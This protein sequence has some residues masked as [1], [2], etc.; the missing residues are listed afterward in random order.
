[1][2]LL[3]TVWIWGIAQGRNQLHDKKCFWRKKTDK[4]FEAFG[5]LAAFHSITTPGDEVLTVLEQDIVAFISEFAFGSFDDFLC[6]ERPAK[7]ITL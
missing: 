1:M 2:S 5:L 3:L 6:G 7:L 4:L